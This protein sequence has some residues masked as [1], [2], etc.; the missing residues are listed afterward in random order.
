MPL[1]HFNLVAG[2]YDRAGPFRV[3]ESLLGLLSLSQSNLLLDVGGGTGR[4]AAA[5]RDRVKKVFVVDVSSGMLRRAHAK[6][7]AT[8]C[9]PAEFLPIPSGSIDRITMVDALHHVADQRQTATELWRVLV[10]GGRIL[11]IEPDI[12]KIAMKLIAIGEKI[13]LMRSHIL[14]GEEISALFADPTVKVS[15]IYEEFNIVFFAE[16]VR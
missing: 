1:D 11:I 12:H 6:G 7:L 16:K 8:V 10:P 14:T 15:V 3:T 5:L 4:V 2:F 13:L 9:A